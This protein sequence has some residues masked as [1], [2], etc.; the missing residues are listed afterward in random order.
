MSPPSWLWVVFTL[1]PPA[2]RWNAA[3]HS[4]TAGSDGGRDH[5]SIPLRPPFG[6]LAL[7][8]FRGLRSAP[9]PCLARLD[10]AGAVNKLRRRR[11]CLR[12]ARALVRRGDRLYEDKSRCS[13]PV[14]SFSSGYGD[15]AVAVLIA[16]VGVLVMSWPKRQRREVFSWR[17]AILGSYPEVFLRW[18]PSASAASALDG[19]SCRRGGNACD[20]ADHPGVFSPVALRPPARRPPRVLAAWRASRAAGFLAPSPRKCGSSLSRCKRRRVRHLPG[21]GGDPCRRLDL[22]PR[23]RKFRP[24][25]PVRISGIPLVLRRDCAA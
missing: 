8:P 23:L 4:L 20:R 24:L 9:A 1:V 12:H 14:R 11:W 2:S 17:P 22:S 3:R 21:L 5:D 16:T 7:A 10:T 15:N 6:L 19:A 25:A 13:R 18:L